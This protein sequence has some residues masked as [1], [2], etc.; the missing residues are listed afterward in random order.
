MYKHKCVKPFLHV[1]GFQQSALWG[2]TELIISVEDYM[3]LFQRT[4]LTFCLHVSEK[5]ITQK[6]T[7]HNWML[8]QLKKNS[9]V[10]IK[11]QKRFKLYDLLVC[12]FA[13]LG[14]NI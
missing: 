11:G 9:C 5:K 14:Q 10:S 2:K 1:N 6:T 8:N 7:A 3:V 13:A 12:F 4:I